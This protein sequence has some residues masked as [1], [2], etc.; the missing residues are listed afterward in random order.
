MHPN[1]VKTGDNVTLE[2]LTSC[3]EPQ[4]VWFKDG[5]PLSE[6]EFQA[7]PQDYGKYVCAV[8][9]QESVQSDPVVIDVQCKYVCYILLFF[10]SKWK[11]WYFSLLFI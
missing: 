7:Q 8:E 2:C 9:G 4:V 5:E 10:K 6:P 1:K 3:T 11:N